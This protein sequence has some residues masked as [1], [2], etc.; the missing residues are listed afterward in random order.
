MKQEIKVTLAIDNEGEIRSYL[1]ISEDISGSKCKL[2]AFFKERVEHRINSWLARRLSREGKEILIKI[3][4]LALP[5]YVMSSFLFSL[6]ICEKLP[7]SI[8]RFWWSFFMSF[9]KCKNDYRTSSIL[10]STLASSSLVMSLAP[11]LVQGGTEDLLFI[12]FRASL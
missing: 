6:E 3:I 9:L 1:G 5:L 4:A 10:P 8:V 12:F 7:S 2:F 11:T